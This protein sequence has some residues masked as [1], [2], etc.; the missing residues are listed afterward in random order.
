MYILHYICIYINYYYIT[1]I[2]SILCSSV[3]YGIIVIIAMLANDTKGFL[4]CI[5]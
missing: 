4:V 3:M 1:G 5:I 2:V